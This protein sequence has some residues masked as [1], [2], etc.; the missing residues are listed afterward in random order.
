MEKS[1]IIEFIDNENQVSKVFR[2][3]DS[4]ERHLYELKALGRLI[5]SCNGHIRIVHT[6]K[7]K[8]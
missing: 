3:W 6:R 5:K 1:I 2:D 8:L 4:A 7:P